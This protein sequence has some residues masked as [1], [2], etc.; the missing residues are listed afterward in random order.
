MLVRTIATIACCAATLAAWQLPAAAGAA[1]G[2]KKAVTYKGKTAQKRGIVFRVARNKLDLRHFSIQ[3]RCKDGSVLIVQESG[4]EPAPLGS[5]GSFREYQVG[6]TDK[7]WFRG[8][9][10]DRRVQGKVKVKDRWGKVRCNS[11]WVKFNA[12]RGG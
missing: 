1:Q 10:T 6:S 8:R 2:S 4:F 3:L 7:V 5:G 9:A 11:G 12:K